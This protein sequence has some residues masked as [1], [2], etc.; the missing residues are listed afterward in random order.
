MRKFSKIGA[1]AL[2]L[3]LSVAF[4][5]PA[6]VNAANYPVKYIELEREKTNV[7]YSSKLITEDNTIIYQ[8][9]DYKAFQAEAAK[10]SGDSTV[11]RVT[12]TVKGNKTY[13][14]VRTTVKNEIS[15]ATGSDAD[16]KATY[17]EE[18]TLTKRIYINSDGP[19]LL[20][21]G[22]RNGD[23]AI[24]KLKS[25]KNSVLTAT[26]DR[27]KGGVAKTDENAD[28]EKDKNGNYYYRTSTGQ[29]II[30]PKN[31]KG[32]GY[33]QESAEYKNSNG[34]AAAVYIKLTPKRCGTSK[35]SF[36]VYNKYGKQTGKIA[37]KITVRSD[38][39][40]FKTFS[41]GGKSLIQKHYGDK[42][43]IN[44]GRK[45]NSY[46]Y[47]LSTKKKGRLVVKA[48]KGYKIVKILVGTYEK[49]KSIKGVDYDKYSN[50]Y[51]DVDNEYGS[52][53]AKGKTNATPHDYN[54]DGDVLDKVYGNYEYNRG[55][56][57]KTVKSGKTIKLGQYGSD[58]GKWTTTEV[59]KDAK[60]GNKTTTIDEVYYS[61]YAPTNIMV[62]YYDI[63]D[64][65]YGVTST[66]I[67]AKAKQPK[68]KKSKK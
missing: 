41:F 53:S 48:N 45:V 62:V 66:T 18:E 4:A 54:G 43:Y 37:V 46:D 23:V 57:Y 68:G 56:K 3:A 67:Y 11:K 60:L 63:E 44:Y 29:K 28:I 38:G 9:T 31:A 47:N 27:S 55:M 40:V 6:S 58:S 64:K 24:K 52:S 1:T 16:P 59:D 25:S 14:L 8:T 26:I 51:Y 49:P 13:Y 35:V 20:G 10:Y 33:D 30:I 39:D 17:A 19:T 42:N 61:D 2:A 36:A 22:L 21:V 12:T 32:T 7:T 15:G 65:Y 50:T 34:S 5:T